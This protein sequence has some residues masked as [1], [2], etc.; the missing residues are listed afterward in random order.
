MISENSKLKLL[1]NFF[2]LTG[3]LNAQKLV[4]EEEQFIAF[5]GNTGI[6]LSSPYITFHLN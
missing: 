6:A 4:R 5:I 3:R 2:I 1:L